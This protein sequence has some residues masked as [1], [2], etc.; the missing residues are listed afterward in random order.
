MGLKLLRDDEDD[1]IRSAYHSD[2]VRKILSGPRGAQMAAAKRIE[3]LYIRTFDKLL[4]GES[5]AEFEARLSKNPK[6]RRLEPETEEER[7][8]RMHMAPS[9]IHGFVKRQSAHFSRRRKPQDVHVAEERPPSPPPKSTV[10]AY[11]EFQ[12]SDHPA[13]PK[14]VQGDGTP[15]KDAM[16]QWNSGLKQAWDSLPHEEREAFVAQAAA[17][18]AAEETPEQKEIRRARCARELPEASQRKMHMWQK[19]AGWVG[20][21]MLGG[22]DEH[23]EVACVMWSTGRDRYKKTFIEA[24]AETFNCTPRYIEI[25]YSKWLCDIFEVPLPPADEALSAHASQPPLAPASADKSHSHPFISPAPLAPQ[26]TPDRSAL[27]SASQ[28]PDPARTCVD[29]ASTSPPLSFEVP[30]S[31]PQATSR[32]TSGVSNVT[33]ATSSN[34]VHPTIETTPASPLRTTT[35]TQGTPEADG[36]RPLNVSPNTK[37]T[38]RSEKVTAAIVSPS[39]HDAT[40]VAGP[41]LD[42]LSDGSSTDDMPD[43]LA[44]VEAYVP[45]RSGPLVPKLTQPV[46][47]TKQCTRKEK[48]VKVVA[49][50]QKARA[51]ASVHKS[52]ENGAENQGQIS[53]AAAKKH[54]QPKKPKPRLKEPSSRPKSP[55]VTG[56]RV[57]HPTAR[58]FGD[59]ADM[60]AAK[61]ARAGSSRMKADS[62]Q[63]A[64]QHAKAEARHPKKK[65]RRG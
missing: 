61:Y 50:P 33:L 56:P 8:M 6:A 34:P 46:V 16:R 22:I 60:S 43:T 30:R 64:V 42:D 10:N 62:P 65:Q 45:R 15:K 52:K 28:V 2:D 12:T 49:R 29:G 4:P 36:G 9:R 41:S 7:A 23:G 31:P 14:M 13:K 26:S 59:L 57:R 25:M 27:P 51:K 19:E 32:V 1:F 20:S 38:S 35:I 58:S 47:S 17:K 40:R 18:R 44:E 54:V 53:S 55:E 24:L 37:Q 5:D 21:L 39:V 11:R 3:Q 63:P 48:A